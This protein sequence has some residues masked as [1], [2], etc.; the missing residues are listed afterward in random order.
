MIMASAPPVVLAGRRAVL[1]E[2]IR[3]FP[4]LTLSTVV[5]EIDWLNSQNLTSDEYRNGPGIA[6]VGQVW[7]HQ[8]A[9]LQDSFISYKRKRRLLDFDD[10]LVECTH[11]LRTDKAFR[12]AQHWV[13]SSLLRR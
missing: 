9:D 12:D 5:T 8:V 6:R 2:I 3:D 1:T 4:H 11:L 7:A 10:I 13:L